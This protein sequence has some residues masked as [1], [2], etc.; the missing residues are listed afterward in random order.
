M[1]RSQ[2]ELT[3]F[4]GDHFRQ[5]FQISAAQEHAGHKANGLASAPVLPYLMGWMSACRSNLIARPVLMPGMGAWSTHET[6]GMDNFFSAAI[7]VS[8]GF[9]VKP[10]NIQNMSAEHSV[11]LGSQVYRCILQEGR[12]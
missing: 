8:R 3:S 6:P 4:A 2:A 5:P 1:Q 11:S 10:S 7:S 9:S 12:G